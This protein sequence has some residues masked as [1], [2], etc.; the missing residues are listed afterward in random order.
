MG[1]KKRQYGDNFWLIFV[2]FQCKTECFNILFHIFYFFVVNK[3]T[4]FS[5]PAPHILGEIDTRFSF[6]A[7]ATL[8]LLVS[9][10]A[11]LTQV[12]NLI[13]GTAEVSVVN[14]HGRI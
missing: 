10:K 4:L 1:W 6:C 8:A 5:F 11:S 2:A 7:A 13:F 3:N 14:E 9:L 12:Q